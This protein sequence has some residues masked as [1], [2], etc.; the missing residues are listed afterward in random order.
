MITSLSV[1]VIAFSDA[2]AIALEFYDR[3]ITPPKGGKVSSP[4]D[5]FQRIAGSV[6]ISN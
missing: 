2:V 4:V 5:S 3:R 1:T 6:A